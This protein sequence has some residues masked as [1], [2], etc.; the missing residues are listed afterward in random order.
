VRATRLITDVTPAHELVASG[1]CA[2]E[3][4]AANCVP[5]EAAAKP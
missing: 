3:P 1:V 4:A 5:L 2:R